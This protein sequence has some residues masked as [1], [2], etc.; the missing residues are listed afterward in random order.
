MTAC[1]CPCTALGT[2]S[3]QMPTSSSKS[4]ELLV[5]VSS[6]ALKTLVLSKSLILAF[7]SD[8]VMVHAIPAS[9]VQEYQGMPMFE[10]VGP[11]TMDP[12]ID[13]EFSLLER[14]IEESKQTFFDKVR[15]DSLTHPKLTL[16]QPFQS[17][18]RIHSSQICIFPS[19]K[20]QVSELIKETEMIIALTYGK[21]V[22]IKIV[23]HVSNIVTIAS[24]EQ[25]FSC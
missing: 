6:L 19:V 14:Q 24:E 1:L 10:E 23:R 22:V 8:R 12:A 25:Q 4:Q 5:P 11:L 15:V 18:L 2:T 9:D 7:N 13:Q 21:D 3:L 20:S 16:S 17:R